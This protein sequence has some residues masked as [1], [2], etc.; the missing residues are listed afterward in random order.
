MT[1]IAAYHLEVHI[2]FIHFLCFFL[3]YSFSALF[4]HFSQWSLIAY[5]HRKRYI[6]YIVSAHISQTLDHSY[7][8]ETAN[9]C[10]QSATIVSFSFIWTPTCLCNGNE[11]KIYSEVREHFLLLNAII[12]TFLAGLLTNRSTDLIYFLT[13]KKKTNKIHRTESH[14]IH[15][16]ACV[17]DHD[18][19]YM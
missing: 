16:N 4:V 7:N 10:R 17:L 3:C 19:H 13:C 6:P 12:G 14:R 8:E 5:V 18:M 2:K 15:E 9:E 11:L 1:F